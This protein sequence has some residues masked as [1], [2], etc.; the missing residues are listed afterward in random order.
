MHVKSILVSGAAGFIGDQ[1]L[2]RLS[3]KG[4]KVLGLDSRPGRPNSPIVVAD[5]STNN[6]SQS[7]QN[8]KF[9]CIVH[10]AAQTDVRASVE[11]PVNDLLINSLGTL[12]LVQ[13]AESAG[14]ENFLY[15]NSGGAIYSNENLPLNENSVIR[16]A[17]PY[18]LSKFVGEEYLR[19]LSGKSGM[20]W[21]S[22]ALSNVY[23]DITF[24]KKG[25]IFEFAKA[26]KSKHTPVIYGSEITRDFIHVDDVLSAVEISINHPINERINISSNKETSILDVYKLVSKHFNH[27]EMPQIEDP[28]FGE[29]TRSCLDNS[30][31]K[32]L[33][34]WVPTID[35][36]SGVQ[37]SLKSVNHETIL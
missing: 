11:D 25:V 26:I 8:E 35:I 6:L 34:G 33:M 16:P 21:S 23:G 9:D 4:H 30:K 2:K 28:R 5:I 31:A 7:L 12:K 3:A 32:K 29:I 17:S 14:I 37:D 15:I 20:K 19:I 13:Y 24:N 36:V 27:S 18:G 22:L 10:C 1:V